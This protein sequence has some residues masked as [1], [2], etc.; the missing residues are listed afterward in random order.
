MSLVKVFY[1]QRE[2]GTEL[3]NHER[4]LKFHREACETIDNY[5]WEK[6]LEL[7][8]E[9]GEGGG[10]FFTLGDM[11]GKFASYQFTPVESDRG[12]LDLQV[13][14]KPGFIGIFGRKS[15][16]VD[17]KL[18]SIPEAKQHIKELFEYSIDSL[19]QKYRK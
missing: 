15:V 4:D 9:L 2:N 13:V 19:Y 3:V 17:F 7:F 14:S 11:D 16:S 6:E 18:V 10:F 1:Q 8:E 5:P 12:S